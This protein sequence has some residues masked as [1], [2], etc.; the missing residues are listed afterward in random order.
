MV[1]RR[2]ARPGPG[3]MSRR[4]GRRL[5]HLDPPEVHVHVATP[6]LGHRLLREPDGVPPGPARTRGPQSRDDVPRQQ[7]AQRRR[8][9]AAAP[10][11]SSRIIK[12]YGGRGAGRPARPGRGRGGRQSL[13]LRPQ[14]HP[15]GPVRGRRLAGLGRPRP[16]GR[17]PAGPGTGRESRP[18]PWPGRPLVRRQ[19][20]A[21]PHGRP[22]LAVRRPADVV[23]PG[24]GAG[25]RMS[26][27]H[28]GFTSV[29]RVRA[30]RPP[31]RQAASSQTGPGHAGAR[32]PG[33][34]HVGQ[35]G[36]RQ[37]E[38]G[39]PGPGQPGPTRPRPPRPEPATPGPASPWSA[40]RSP[41]RRSPPR[42]SQLHLGLPGR[43]PP[44]RG[45][46]DRGPPG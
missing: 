45:P 13:V 46:P 29:A 31:A 28:G 33:A 25:T 18:G 15:G 3:G 16:R 6:A 35:V 1:R 38:I 5:H 22:R 4:G 10:P 30:R 43:G 41:P 9:Q 14:L 17:G 39:Q 32:Q 26:A 12:Y 42:R 34:S 20:L 36:A 21:G 2:R 7:L 11:S 8:S 27:R 44:D 24:L 19:W 37:P 23:A 40:T